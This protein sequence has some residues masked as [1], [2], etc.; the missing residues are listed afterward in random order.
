MFLSCL[1]AGCQVPIG[2]LSEISGNQIIIRAVV[3]SPDGTEEIH[4]MK[5]GEVERA[6]EIA[7]HL[8]DEVMKKGAKRLIGE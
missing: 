4:A 3:L 8:A 1:G 2:V 7:R 5:R 6:L